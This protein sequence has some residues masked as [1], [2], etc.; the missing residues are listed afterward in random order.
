L[1]GKIDFPFARRFV[2]LFVWLYNKADAIVTVIEDEYRALIKYGAQTEKISI[3]PH[4]ID[5]DRFDKLARAKAVEKLPRKEGRRIALYLGTVG[6]AHDIE[7]TVEAFAHPEIR[8]LPVD[9]II[10]GDGEC[11]PI[12]RR[13]AERYNLDNVV[14][15]TPV[16]MNSVPG[17]LVQADILLL[18]QKPGSFSLGS[19]FCEYMTAGKPLLANSDGSLGKIIEGL[20]NGWIFDSRNP[21]TLRE[22]LLGFLNSTESV[23][24]RMGRMSREYAFNRLNSRCRHDEWEKLLNSVAGTF[25]ETV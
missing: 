8:K 12:C 17:I 4:G 24:E 21:Q 15:R 25:R 1:R 11:L 2:C 16:E 3:I 20:G 5:V 23:V 13:I 22:A 9:F 10:V 7:S 19:K 18:S 6:V 14:F